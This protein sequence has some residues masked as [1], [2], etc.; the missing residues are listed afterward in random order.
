MVAQQEIDLVQKNE[1]IKS[2]FIF[3]NRDLHKKDMKAP[4]LLPKG[5]QFTSIDLSVVKSIFAPGVGDPC[6]AMGFSDEEILDVAHCIGS[7]R[8]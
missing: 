2:E 6:P 4:Q 5:S 7:D 3:V 8:N 1:K